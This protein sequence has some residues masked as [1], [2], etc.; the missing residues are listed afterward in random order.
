[1]QK[2]TVVAAVV[3]KGY[4]SHQVV[5][6]VV[7][8]QVTVMERLSTPRKACRLVRAL[9]K[10]INVY[11][12]QHRVDHQWDEH[13]HRLQTRLWSAIYRHRLMT[14]WDVLWTYGKSCNTSA[15]GVLLWFVELMVQIMALES[16]LSWMLFTGHIRIRLGV[17]AL[18]L[19]CVP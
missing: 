4:Q 17:Y 7:T 10:F 2:A 9:H 11:V 15:T 8:H 6:M 19:S 18:L 13:C 3:Q 5:A 1:V 16:Q 12:V 14:S